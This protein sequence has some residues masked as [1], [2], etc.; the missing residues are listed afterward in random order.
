MFNLKNSSKYKDLNRQIVNMLFLE[1]KIVTHTVRTGF[2]IV[3][4]YE[5]YLFEILHFHNTHTP[6]CK[7]QK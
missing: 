5:Q 2:M 6:Q 4:T 3:W 7:M 1:H